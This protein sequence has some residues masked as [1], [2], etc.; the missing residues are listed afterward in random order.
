MTASRK[1]AHDKVFFL[2]FTKGPFKQ[3]IIDLQSKKVLALNLYIDINALVY[4]RR[5]MMK[6]FVVKKPSFVKTAVSSLKIFELEIFLWLTQAPN[7][8]R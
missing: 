8:S 3:K 5:L 4:E 2:N 6:V 7:T 1:L